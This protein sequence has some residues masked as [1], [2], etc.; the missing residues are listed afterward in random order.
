M[1]ATK[2][3][4][5]KP[6]QEKEKPL[7]AAKPSFLEK[8]SALQKKTVKK[9]KTAQE[10]TAPKK[11][12]PQATR[13]ILSGID[14]TAVLENGLT[15]DVKMKY[16]EAVGRRK[17][18]SARVRLFTQG[19]KDILVNG[20]PHTVYFPINEWQRVVE[21]P[22]RKLNVFGKFGFSIQVRGGGVEGQAEA[23]R[24]GIA[25]TLVLLNP[26]FKKRLKKSGFLTRDPRMRERKKPGLKRAR[27]AP[28][29]SKR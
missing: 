19:F 2:K 9:T 21:D 25:R 13:E 26:Y 12:E 29:W 7:K 5:K 3:T 22:A 17:T 23:A 14:E 20:K 6:P 28:Q 8:K 18:A 16:I 27:R 15:K 10:K 24:M 1:T 11:Q 4:T